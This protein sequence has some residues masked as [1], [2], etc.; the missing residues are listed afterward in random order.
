[1]TTNVG[2]PI[3]D[4]QNSLRA[5]TRGPTLLEDYQLRE[6][7]QHFDHERIPERIVHARGAAAHGVFQVYDDS[8]KDLTVGEGADGP[9]ARDARL[10]AL[11]HR[12]RLAR[13]GRHRPRR[14]RL[15]RQDVHARRQLGPRR[16]Q[17]P[18]LL[19]PGRHQVPRSD[20]RRQARAGQRDPAGRVRP[21]HVLRLHLA[22]PRVHAHAD[23]GHERPGHPPLVRPDG[24]LRRP[25]LPPGQRRGQVDVRQVPLE[26][27]ARRALAGLGRGPEDRRQ[28]PRL[29]PPH[30]VGRHQSRATSSSGNWA[31]RRW[32][33]RTR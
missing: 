10:R 6:K 4:D 5:G 24:R 20:P 22:D 9:V 27:R 29:P 17:H 26:A 25:H 18:R 3:G 21:R 23:V 16:Q 8:L 11:L 7:I 31:S 19:H 32:P 2:Q 15:R 30:H 12:R 1:M 14:A 28:G 13:L 33:R